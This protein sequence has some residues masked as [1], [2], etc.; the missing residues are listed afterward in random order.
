MWNI[1]A[2]KCLTAPML[3]CLLALYPPCDSLVELN[4]GTVALAI[5]NHFMDV[6]EVNLKLCVEGRDLLGDLLAALYFLYLHMK[7]LTL[8]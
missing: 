3:L 8:P 6:R 4:Y 7:G 1:M 5:N 2:C